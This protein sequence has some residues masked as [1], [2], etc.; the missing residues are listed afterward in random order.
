MN[1]LAMKKIFRR[2]RKGIRL[3]EKKRKPGTARTEDRSG[4]LQEEERRTGVEEGSYL[5]RSINNRKVQDGK[6]RQSSKFK[7]GIFSQGRGERLGCSIGTGE[8]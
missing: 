1:P 7:E 3:Q 4:R 6:L 8:V 2:R 5:R